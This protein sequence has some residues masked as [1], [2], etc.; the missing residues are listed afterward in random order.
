MPVA[1]EEILRLAHLCLLE[2]EAA[3][4][5]ELRQLSRL[6]V[7]GGGLLGRERLALVRQ[8]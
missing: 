1:L 7:V 8:P 2:A 5:A 6:V 3:E 4:K